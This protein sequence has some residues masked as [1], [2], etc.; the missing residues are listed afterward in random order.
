MQ[1]SLENF[2]IDPWRKSTQ[3]KAEVENLIFI[4]ICLSC[5]TNSYSSDIMLHIVARYQNFLSRKRNDEVQKDWCRI[6]CFLIFCLCTTLWSLSCTCI[7]FHVSKDKSFV[8]SVCLSVLLEIIKALTWI[9]WKTFKIFF[10][11]SDIILKT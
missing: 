4:R 11:V 6:G 10:F 7:N 5:T 3:W 1:L 9:A 2:T 8:T